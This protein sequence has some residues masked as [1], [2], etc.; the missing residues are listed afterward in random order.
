MKNKPRRYTRSSSF[1]MAALF[2]LL[3]G[4]AA[5]LLGYFLYDFSRANFIRETEAAIDNEMDHMLALMGG[6]HQQNLIEHIQERSKKSDYPLYFYRTTDGRKLAG[7]IERIPAN[8][9][10]IKEGVLQFTIEKNNRKRAVASKIH[11]FSDGSSLLIA[12][13]IHDITRTYERLKLFSILIILFMLIVV[14]VSFFI[15]VFVVGRI[16]T[17]ANTAQQIMDTGDLS[18]RISVDTNW[19]DLSNL[20]HTLNALLGRVESLMQG[21]RDVSDSIA[22]DLRTPLTRLRNQ[23]EA[24]REKPLDQKAVDALLMEADHLLATFNALL[25][26]SN[27]EKGKRHQAFE[28]VDL[29]IVLQ[30]VVELYEP[31]AE[32]KQIAI[33]TAYK[34]CPHISGDRDL[35]FQL[36]ANLLDNAIKFSPEG[37]PVTITLDQIKG[38]LRITISDRGIG[39]AE[40]EK[41]KVFERFYRSDKSRHTEGSGLGLSLAKAALELHKGTIS[42]SNNTPGLRI[43]ILFPHYQ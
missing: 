3:L 39:I 38:N 29:Q 4:T 34:E 1:K 30:D 5:L 13:D 32:E 31:L 10:R 7:N 19:D 43:E 8:V 15:S 17:I 24:A 16:N 35:L 20:A 40:E 27:I 12:R 26:I 22:H 6:D 14:L 33:E 2:T 21:I 18:Q 42:L 37:S 41:E 28:E 9:E 25:R 36:F 11:T 23:L